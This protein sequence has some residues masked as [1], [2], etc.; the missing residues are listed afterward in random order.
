MFTV[1]TDGPDYGLAELRRWL[2]WRD[3]QNAQ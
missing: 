3:E 1:I 2:A